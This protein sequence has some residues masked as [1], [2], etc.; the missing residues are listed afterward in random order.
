MLASDEIK[1]VIDNTRWTSIYDMLIRYIRLV[2]SL[3]EIEEENIIQKMPTQIEIMATKTMLVNLEQ[4]NAIMKYLQ[5]E[6][7]NLANAR[8][9]FD[10]LLKTFPAW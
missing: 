1:G 9:C 3:Q 7:I 10:A 6:N 2:P 5:R 4:I 8:G